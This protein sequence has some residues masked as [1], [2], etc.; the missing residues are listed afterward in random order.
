MRT[1]LFK[2][3]VHNTELVDIPGHGLGAV[4][5]TVRKGL[6]WAD[7]QVGDTVVIA[8]TGT[9][10]AEGAEVFAEIFDVKVMTFHALT[11]YTHIVKLFHDP[12]CQTFQ[13]LFDRMKKVY[14]GF[15]LHEVVTLVFYEIVSADDTGH[16]IKTKTEA[17]EVT[18][19][20]AETA[21]TQET[22]E[23][24]VVEETDAD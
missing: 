18:E 10:V 7:L 3:N 9:E 2:N 16:V 5:L 8:E 11:H 22:S 20:V 12:A 4:N 13:G 21:D 19:E 14:D 15:I 23:A 17:K 1:L 24:E 6:K